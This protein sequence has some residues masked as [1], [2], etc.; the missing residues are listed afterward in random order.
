MISADGLFGNH[1]QPLYKVSQSLHRRLR[2]I[3]E[4]NAYI[5]YKK[6]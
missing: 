5:W 4:K 6:H 1:L 3:L 2:K